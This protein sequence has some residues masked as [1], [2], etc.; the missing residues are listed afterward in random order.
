M[1]HSSNTYPYGLVNA[2]SE[3]T[4]RIPHLFM[5]PTERDHV[6]DLYLIDLPEPDHHAPT[7]NVVEIRQIEEDLL[8]TISEEST[9]STGSLRTNY[10]RTIIDPYGQEFLAF[11][12]GFGGTVFA[13]SNDK[14][15]ATGRPI[16]RGLLRRKETPTIRLRESTWRM[17]KR[18]RLTQARVANTISAV[19]WPTHST[20]VTTSKFSRH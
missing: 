4:T 19:I 5:D 1:A 11:P 20:C 15:L 10:T 14:P 9:R 18:M 16:K 7:V 12:P 17:P 13:V 6:L 3:Y 8:S 2:A